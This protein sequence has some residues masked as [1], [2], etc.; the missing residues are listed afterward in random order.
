MDL[1]K[2]YGEARVKFDSNGTFR[3]RSLSLTD[4]IFEGQPQ[5]HLDIVRPLVRI[6]FFCSPTPRNPATML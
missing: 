3:A 6:P 5:K 1:Y 4:P 2:E